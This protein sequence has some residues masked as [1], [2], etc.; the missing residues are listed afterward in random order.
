MPCICNALSCA[1]A[2]PDMMPSTL[3]KWLRRHEQSCVTSMSRA[4]GGLSNVGHSPPTR[5]TG[6]LARFVEEPPLTALVPRLTPG[7]TRLTSAE[8][9]IRALQRLAN[10]GY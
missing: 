5:P 2:P 7:R 10:A 1:C 4:P 9:Y 8:P 6:S 3:R